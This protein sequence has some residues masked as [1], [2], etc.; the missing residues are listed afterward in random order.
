MSLSDLAGQ[1]RARAAAAWLESGRGPH[2][3]LI[4]GVEGTGKRRFALELAK[5]LLCADQGPYS[6]DS[7]SSC[8]SAAALRHP[9]LHAVLPLPPRRGKREASPEVLREAVAEYVLTGGQ[10]PPGNANIAIE[11]LRQLIF[12]S[13]FVAFL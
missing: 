5:A 9:D 8:R 11:Y 4:C 12:R 6:C 3:I 1:D 10:S 7:C 13:S 2:A